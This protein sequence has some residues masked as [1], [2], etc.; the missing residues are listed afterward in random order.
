MDTTDQAGCWSGLRALIKPRKPTRAPSTNAQ[1]LS[2]QVSEPPPTYDSH[3]AEKKNLAQLCGGFCDW[4]TLEHGMS[5]AGPV[6]EVEL[7]SPEAVDTSDHTIDELD[8]ALREVNLKIHG[9]SLLSL[10]RYA[11]L[12]CVLIRPPRAGMGS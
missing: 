1:S 9:E 2:K 10:C 3:H 4:S 8:K 5:L 12:T 7:P 6:G 11:Q